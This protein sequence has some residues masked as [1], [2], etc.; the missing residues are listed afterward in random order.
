MPTGKGLDEALRK[1]KE[2]GCTAVQVFTSSPQMW[3]AKALTQDAIDRFHA[4]KQE[5]GIHQIISHDTYLVNLCSPNEEIREK[6]RAALAQEL[7]RC[8]ALGIPFVV[9]HMGAHMGQGEAEGLR[10]VA[11]V[12]VQ[13][14]D[15][16]DPSVTL[17]METTAGQ[18][19][20]LNWQFE[21][22]ATILDMAHRPARLGVCLDTCHIFSAG[23]ELR[24]REGYEKT[25]GE[26]DRLVGLDR[27]GAIHLN[28][29]KF[30][31]GSRKDRHEHLGQG[32]IGEMAF[33]MLVNDPRLQEVPMVIETPEAETEH[34]VNVGRLWQW[35]GEPLPYNQ[36]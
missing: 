16:T 10:I 11:E 20:A 33:R 34:A 28:D 17:L 27:L 2:I 5:T 4:A 18:G 7:G 23:Y 31:L 29:S 6:S 14:L 3:R 1:G 24:D 9:S 21:Q 35:A 22:L 15:E 19:S 32:G 25:F 26:F 12:A 30:G 13:I 36:G 8:T